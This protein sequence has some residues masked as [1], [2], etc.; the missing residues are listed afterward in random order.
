MLHHIGYVSR[1]VEP[2][3]EV[4]LAEILDVSVRNNARDDITG[5]LMYHDELFF[6][7]LEGEKSRVENCYARIVHDL[8]H[9]SVFLSLDHT[10]EARTFA[11]WRMGYAGSDE[12]GRMQWFGA[13]SLYINFINI[14]VSILQ[15]F[16]NRE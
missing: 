14:F 16:G 13:L 3:D 11:D 10:I 8:R 9:N 15:L 5:V 2:L 12:I 6:Q 1:S 4:V 7:I